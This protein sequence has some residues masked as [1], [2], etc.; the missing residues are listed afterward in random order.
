MRCFPPSVSTR[1]V[2]SVSGSDVQ[3]GGHT[4][5]SAYQ[6]HAVHCGYVQAE[7]VSRPRKLPV[8]PGDKKQRIIALHV[9]NIFLYRRV[10][11]ILSV[12][13]CI[14]QVRSFQKEL[15]SSARILPLE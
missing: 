13:N 9:L 3:A 4:L 2:S 7:P 10:V 6:S 11:F 15:I 8:A 1:V 12:H 14:C 5:D